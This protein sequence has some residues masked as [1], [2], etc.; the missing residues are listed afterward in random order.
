MYGCRGACQG[1]E[2]PVRTGPLLVIYPIQGVEDND[3]A[4]VV[5]VMYGSEENTR[6]KEER[7]VWDVVLGG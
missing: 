1:V 3:D 2:V 6:I 7:G 5:K 4:A